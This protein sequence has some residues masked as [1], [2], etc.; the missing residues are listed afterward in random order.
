MAPFLQ[1]Y[2]AP[3]PIRNQSVRSRIAMPSLGSLRSRRVHEA[4][5]AQRLVG[6]RARPGP[7][8]FQLLRPFLE[9]GVPLRRVARERGLALRTARRWVAHYRR[10]GLA[11]LARKPRSDK[12]KRHL[13]V[14]LRQAIEGLALQ[15]PRLSAAAIHRQ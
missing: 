7:G 9:E 6:G 13:S 2:L 1:G 12:D 3:S 4:L 10:D 14:G 15:K 11:G 8:R 5:P